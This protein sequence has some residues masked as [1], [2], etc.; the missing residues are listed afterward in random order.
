[1]SK[2][3]KQPRIPAGRLDFRMVAH[4]GR[5]F[6]D[7]A[8]P[9]LEAL[10]APLDVAASRAAN[11]GELVCAATLVALG[12]ELLLKSIY[13]GRSMQIPESH[14]LL[15]LFESLP[16]A[17]RRDIQSRY[18]AKRDAAD[19]SLATEIEIRMVE[20]GKP[21]PIDVPNIP[22]EKR[23]YSLAALLGRCADSFV[24]WRY[25]YES[26]PHDRPSTTKVIE[27][28]PLLE[29]ADALCEFIAANTL[30]VPA[31]VPKGSA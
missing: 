10:H 17:I 7:L 20:Q 6:L 26:V 15:G 22:K 8:R 1:M 5:C 23:D 13:V 25:F 29:L 3:K 21:F 19:Q 12:L 11:I 16:E 9:K 2:K 18:S 30:S 24:V 4:Q 31:I 28:R 14:N 27:H